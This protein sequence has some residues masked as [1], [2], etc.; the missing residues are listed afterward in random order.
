MVNGKALL[1]DYKRNVPL[2]LLSTKYKLPIYMIVEVLYY[3]ATKN[4]R[5]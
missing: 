2:E 3:Y 4:I 5:R 1:R